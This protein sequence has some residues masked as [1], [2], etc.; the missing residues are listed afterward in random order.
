M[1]LDLS[2]GRRTAV[3]TSRL[4]ASFAGCRFGRNAVSAEGHWVGRAQRPLA[5]AALNAPAPIRKT[6]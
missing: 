5:R 4:F 1:T 6:K 2:S 3:Q